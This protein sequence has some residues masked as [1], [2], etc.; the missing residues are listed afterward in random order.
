MVDL[1]DIERLG[2]L[3]EKENYRFR[4]FLKENADEEELDKQFKELH[5]KY[6]KIYD[7]TKCRNCC[8]KI[9]TII[10]EDE[11]T[12]ICE[13]L[14]LD[15]R[16]VSD[17]LEEK[18]GEYTFKKDKCLFL[19]GNTC[20]VEKCLP[21]ACKEYPYTNKEER[22]FSLYSVISNASICPV[23]YEILEE[24]KKIYKFR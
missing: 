16:F 4:V 13:E 23:V 8:K 15:E 6:F 9:G 22:L 14:K 3:K 7:C 11:L 12:K 17:N 5:E 24:L 2:K 1:N 18:Y 10:K 19:D 20:K 21:I